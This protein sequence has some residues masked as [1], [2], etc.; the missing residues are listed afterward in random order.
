VSYLDW[1]KIGEKM[2]QD[3]ADKIIAISKEAEIALKDLKPGQRKTF[4]I[5]IGSITISRAKE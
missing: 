3:I 4:P 2:R 1:E 5:K